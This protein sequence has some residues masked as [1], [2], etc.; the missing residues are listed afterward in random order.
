MA[1][2]GS[3][4]GFRLFAEA[5]RRHAG[6]RPAWRAAQ[7][8]DA[9]QVVIVGAGGHG[10]ATA[11]DLASEHGISDVAVLEKGP[12]GL[13]NVGRNTT[14]IRSTY[15]SAENIR[16]YDVS[17][18]LW[19]RSEQDHGFN[20]MV[21]QR[22]TLNLFHSEGQRDLFARRAN[23]MLLEGVD[24]E[25]VDRA[26]VKRLAPLVDVEGGR[27]PVLGGFLQRR[28]G[29]VRHDAVPWAYARSA[30]RRGVDICEHC[31]V[32]GIRVE[33]GR[34]TGVETTRGFV[35][36]S[37]VVLAVAGHSSRLA[38]RATRRSSAIAATP[39]S[40]APSPRRMETRRPRLSW[41][42]PTSVRTR[43]AGTSNGGSMP[44]AAGASSR[45]GATH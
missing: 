8:K 19:E 20:A 36:A 12:L 7:P 29:T 9:Y 2:S 11:P 1:D 40:G 15:F 13:G 18:R 44:R 42:M 17:L 37:K 31:E 3:Y 14:I 27:F 16:F 30:S 28:G 41:P 10:L 45:S 25:F 32:T 23:A 34:V 43:G 21:G 4:S 39:A 5:L 6:W 35:R 33:R 26:G 24:G 22:G 38:A